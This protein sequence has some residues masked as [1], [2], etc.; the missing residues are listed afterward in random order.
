MKVKLI[1]TILAALALWAG[2]QV[3]YGALPHITPQ[4]TSLSALTGTLTIPANGL[5]LKSDMSAKQSKPTLEAAK[6]VLGQN[7]IKV[8]AKSSVAIRLD[9]DKSVAPEGYRLMAAPT[10]ITVEASDNAGFFYALQTLSQALSQRDGDRMDCFETNDAPRF[11]YRGAMIDVSRYF[12]PLDDLKTLVDIASTLKLNNIHLHLTDDNGWRLEIKKYP[13][14]TEVGAWR[15]DRPE[16]FPARENQ[17]EGEKA[18][19]GGFYTQKEMREL[20]KYAAERHVNIIPEIEMPAHAVAALASYPELTCPVQEEFFGVLPGI[21][22]HAASIIACAGN[23][24][25]YQFYEDVLAEVM[26]IFP[27]KYIHLGGDEAEKSHW[28]KCPK[29]NQKLKELGLD[30]FEQLQAYFMDRINAFVRKHGR[31]AMGWDE[32]TYGNPKEEMVVMGW[33]GD[34]SIAVRDAMKSS[35]SFIMTPAAKLYLIRYQGPQWFEPFTY[36]GNN[37]LKDVY[38]YEAI[39][40][41]WPD[42]LRKKYLGIQGSLWTEFCRSTSDAQYLLFPR[43]VALADNAWRAEGSGSWPEF[44]KALDAYIPSLENRGVTFARSMFNLDHRV[45]PLGDGTVEVEL[46]CI[47]P[48]VDIVWDTDSTFSNPRHYVSPIALDAVTPASIYAATF[49][50]GRQLGRTLTLDI[51]NSTKSFGRKVKSDNC[52]NRRQEVLTNG[53]RG[54]DRN[55]DFEWAGW[56]NDVATIT[57]DL[58]TAQPI[59][60]V[61]VGNLSNIN[62]CIAAPRHLYLFVSEN[63]RSFRPAGE[64]AVDDA[65]VY[66]P[67]S[68][69]RDFTFENV[70]EDARYVKVVA[71]NPGA[72]PEGMP[73]EG[74]PT[75]LY[76]DEITVD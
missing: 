75:F 1:T 28:R 59:D 70:G 67:V 18:T 61:T 73:R 74:S 23:E 47:R 57:L 52:H 65:A 76:F 20:V 60:K 72:V 21:G 53:L 38:D 43:W 64:I 31:T 19:Y 13:K 62:L 25:T 33:Q 40:D 66:T 69:I 16:I 63:G 2:P 35:R 24:K 4:P 9:Y 12:M 50:D 51:D 7:G 45:R 39:T 3:V 22:G 6:L 71:V 15:V 54:S 32:V 34:G 17:K 26:D 5:A 8:D 48:D 11:A 42:S 44:L 41:E 27:S 46:S 37:T 49:A 58:G 14:L 30:N 29:C 55:S 68:T 36:F 56:Y 10:G